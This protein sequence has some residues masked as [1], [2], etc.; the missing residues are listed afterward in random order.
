MLAT[1]L[2]FWRVR[3]VAGALYLPYWLLKQECRNALQELRTRLQLL[4]SRC[5]SDID[6]LCGAVTP[7]D[8]ALL[9]CL[10]GNREK[11]TANCQDELKRFQ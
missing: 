9:R 7:G 2:L 4:K 6:K 8:G 10:A 5:Q 3:P 11:A 1:L